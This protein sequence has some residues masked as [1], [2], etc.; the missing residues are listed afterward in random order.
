M[1]NSTVIVELSSDSSP[2]ASPAKNDESDRI[3]A[4]INKYKSEQHTITKRECISDSDEETVLLSD[5]ESD[6]NSLSDGF[7][8]KSIFAHFSSKNEI[9]ENA[10]GKKK[11]FHFKRTTV[12]IYNFE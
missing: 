2:P 3:A 5:G 11:I 10:K 6:K 4:L 9:I 12:I 8:R 7:H 1:E